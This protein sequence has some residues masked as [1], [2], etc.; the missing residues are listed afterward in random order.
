MFADI[1][2]TAEIFYDG[3]GQLA[4]VQPALRQY[5]GKATQGSAVKN[6]LKYFLREA[7]SFYPFLKQMRQFD[8]IIVVNSIIPAFLK[9]FFRD[10]AVRYWLP[11][12]PIVLYDVF[13][14][15]T[16]GPWGRWLREGNPSKGVAQ[17]GHWG[18][19]RYDWY[20]V[21]SVVS[22][23][24]LPAGRQ[25][26]SLVGL[27]FVHDS[28]LSN[29]RKNSSR[30]STLKFLNTWLSEQFRSLAAKRPRRNIRY[31]MDVIP[32][33][34]FGRCT[35]KVVSFSSR[36]ARVLAFLYANCKHAGVTC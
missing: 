7:P 6:I 23:C 18:L 31:Y 19:E 20:L 14:L 1:A 22:E 9:E 2:V 25:P 3:H 36:I 10:E 24:P 5:L 35:G 15:P 12:T 32:W 26:Y 21:G 11:K 4:K 33:K 8:V 30:L 34:I 17:P 13:Y 29:R 27:N 16:R 28:L